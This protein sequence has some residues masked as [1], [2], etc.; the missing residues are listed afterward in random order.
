[1]FQPNDGLGDWGYGPRADPDHLF[2]KWL[3]EQM[4]RRMEMEMQWE[5]EAAERDVAEY[6]YQRYS[7]GGLISSII[8]C[9]VFIPLQVSLPC[10]CCSRHHQYFY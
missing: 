1:M 5:Q 10:L 9:M 3:R 6:R 4:R 2:E 7:A 8:N